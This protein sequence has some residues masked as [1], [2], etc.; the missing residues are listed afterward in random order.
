MISAKK[1]SSNFLYDFKLGSESVN[2]NAMAH[3]IVS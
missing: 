3:N 1:N 2:R